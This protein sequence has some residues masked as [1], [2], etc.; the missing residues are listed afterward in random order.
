MKKVVAI[1]AKAYHHH[2][3]VKNV[4]EKKKREKP[5]NVD[6]KK[7]NN[8]ILLCLLLCKFFRCTASKIMKRN[9]KTDI[10]KN[11][12]YPKEDITVCSAVK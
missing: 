5:T 6:P 9:N 12:R 8:K 10:H 3:K 11:D 4:Y 2:F 7:T 1:V